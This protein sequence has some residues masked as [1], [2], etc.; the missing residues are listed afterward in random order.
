MTREEAHGAVD[1]LFDRL[2]AAGREPMGCVLAVPHAGEHP[3]CNHTT[4]ETSWELLRHPRTAT[5]LHGA[6]AMLRLAVDDIVSR[7]DFD[8]PADVDEGVRDE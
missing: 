1:R 8:P 4:I 6:V 3:D 7:E 2:E 5:V